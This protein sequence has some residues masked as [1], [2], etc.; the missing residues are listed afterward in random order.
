MSINYDGFIHILFRFVKLPYI[1]TKNRTDWFTPRLTDAVPYFQHM[2][3]KNRR[4]A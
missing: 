1:I 2:D 3:I 4:T